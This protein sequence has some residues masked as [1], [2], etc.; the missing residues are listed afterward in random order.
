MTIIQTHELWWNM[1]A[2]TSSGSLAIKKRETKVYDVF[3]EKALKKYEEKGNSRNFTKV[4]SFN[5]LKIK[6]PFIHAV[7]RGY[8]F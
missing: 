5:F 6:K 4:N 3:P 7:F 2:G 1:Q 8:I